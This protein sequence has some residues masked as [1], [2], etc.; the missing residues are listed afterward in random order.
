MFNQGWYKKAKCIKSPN[1]NQR[2]DKND[3]SL[4]VIHCISLPEGEYANCNVEKFFTNQLDCSLHPSF[5]S[6]EGVEVSA[7]FYIK[8]DGEIV[9]FVSVDDRAW[10]AGVSEFQGRQGCND[11]SVGIELQGTDK[12]AYTEQQ[13]LSLNSL[14]KDLR[15]ASPTL[16]NITG[17]EDIAPQRKT[18]PGKCFEWNK[19]IW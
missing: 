14:L 3:I 1:F 7:H 17:H 5:A 10:H 15:K 4:V 13:Y 16:L 8:R 12:T 2:A 18:D 6:L 9:Q 11:F 19:V